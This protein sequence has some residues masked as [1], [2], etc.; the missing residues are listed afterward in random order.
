VEG[1]KEF[2]ENDEAFF[3]EKKGLRF[4]AGLYR[5]ARVFE[6][7]GSSLWPFPEKGILKKSPRETG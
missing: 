3:D 7:E 2:E 6:E 1:T 5:S 4:T